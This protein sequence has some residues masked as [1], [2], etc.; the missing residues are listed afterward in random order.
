MEPPPGGVAIDEIWLTNDLQRTRTMARSLAQQA[1]ISDM[2]SAV[3][4][5]V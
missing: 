3:D 5:A 1:L 4:S 2:V